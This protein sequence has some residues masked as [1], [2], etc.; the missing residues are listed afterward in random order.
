MVLD[1]VQ[2]ETE[3]WVVENMSAGGFGAVIQQVKGDWLKIGS[4]LAVQPDSAGAR[5]PWDLAIVRRLSRDGEGAAKNQASVGVQVLA[6]QAIT[7]A[8]RPQQGAWSSGNPSVEG[9]YMA[10]AS[11]PG[12]ALLAMPPGLYMPGEQLQASVAGRRHLLFPIGITERGDDY[13]MIRFRDMVEEG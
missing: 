1:A 4:L 10:D 5:G 3:T 12:A 11:E 7:V 9:I 6:R 13:D 2:P 8:L